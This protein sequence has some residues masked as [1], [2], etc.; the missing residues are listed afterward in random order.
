MTTGGAGQGIAGRWA[1]EVVTEDE[2]AALTTYVAALD[3]LDCL[4]D[5]ILTICSTLAGRPSRS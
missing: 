2:K 5:E 4:T 3:E 1:R